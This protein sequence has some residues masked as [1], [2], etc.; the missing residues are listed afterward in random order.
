MNRFINKYIINAHFDSQDL[1]SDVLDNINNI[2]DIN[3]LEAVKCYYISSKYNYNNIISLRN[4]V[5]NSYNLK[6]SLI[7]NFDAIN[8]SIIK[9]HSKNEYLNY[10]N[11]LRNHY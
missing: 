1:R 8:A 2:N 11:N 10:L 6:D 4:S 3:I 9:I 7:E 5:I